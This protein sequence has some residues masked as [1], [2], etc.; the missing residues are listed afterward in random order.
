MVDQKVEVEEDF[1]SSLDPLN[2]D[3]SLGKIQEAADEIAAQ[4][5][6]AHKWAIIVVSWITGILYFCSPIL[7]PE[8]L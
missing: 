6:A 8:P 1:A 4:I 5:Q 7:D 2:P 3:P